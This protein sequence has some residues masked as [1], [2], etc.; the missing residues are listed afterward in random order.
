MDFI[1]KSQDT[2]DWVLF[3]YFTERSPLPDRTGRGLFHHSFYT[4][5]VKWKI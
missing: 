5:Y 2:L 1:L 4:V 3:F